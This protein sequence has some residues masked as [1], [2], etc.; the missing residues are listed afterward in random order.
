MLADDP[1]IDRAVPSRAAAPDAPQSAPPAKP[2]GLRLLLGGSL[3]L[4]ALSLL[5]PS[6]PTYDP[7]AWIVWGR[8]ISNLDLVTTTGPSWKP[9][10]VVFTTLFSLFGEAAPSLWLVVARAGAIAAVVVAYLLG[11]ALGAGRLGAAAGAVTLATAPWWTVNGW[12]GNSEGLLVACLL[13]ACL[14]HLRGQLRGAFALAVVAGLLRPEAWPFLGLYGLWLLWR[15]REERL[16][17]AAGFALVP[18]LWLVPEQ[19]GSGDLWRASSRAQTD[20]TP[21]SAGRADDPALEIVR[22]FWSLLPLAVWVGLFVAI[23]VALLALRRRQAPPWPVLGLSLLAAAWVGVVAYMAT[24]GYSGNQRYLVAPAAIVLVLAGVGAAAALR[25]LP[26][27]LQPAAALGVVVAFALIGTLD[28]IDAIPETRAQSR[29]T[30]DLK[31]A[32]ERA[33]GTDRLRACG[34]L[35]TEPLLVPQVAW[36]FGTHLQEVAYAPTPGPDAAVMR[37]QV[38]PQLRPYPPESRY[39]GRR[40]RTLARAPRWEILVVGRC[41]R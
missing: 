17:V 16:A 11:R 39:G 1:T 18:L 14:A 27:L 13:G 36:R 23:G 8:E 40:Q 28:S 7:W 3:A 38:S 32:V 37:G 41:A 2:R 9:L 26:R 25:V 30:G 19:L 4:A 15:R 5:A 12:L 10:P 6:S 34:P 33:G 22:D 24:R 20:L 31:A 29:L 35:V 21:G